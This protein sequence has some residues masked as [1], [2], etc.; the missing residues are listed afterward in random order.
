MDARFSL[1]LAVALDDTAE[2]VL[3][4]HGEGFLGVLY[5]L[6]GRDSDEFDV[7]FYKSEMS[8]GYVLKFDNGVSLVEEDAVLSP[9]DTIRD[10]L[11]GWV[12]LL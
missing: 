1:D 12:D 3:A 7:Y 8:S 6:S 11:L 9:Q 2:E 4:S 10:G 5:L